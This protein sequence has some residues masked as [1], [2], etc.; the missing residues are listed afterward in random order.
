MAFNILIVD[1]SHVTRS[2][3][4]RTIKMAGVPVGELYNAENGQG[5]LDVLRAN[6]V[7]LVL[8]DITMPV[9]GAMEM[10]E[11]MSRDPEL[12]SVPVVIVSTEGSETKLEKMRQM[13]MRAFVKKPFMPDRIRE[14]M[15]EVLGG[16][17]EGGEDV[18]SDS[19]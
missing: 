17:E 10:L 14:V 8:A 1:D 9:M 7:D 12:R 5:A 3:I 13:G 16:W 4:A 2:M 18:S 15:R 6:W 19:F 11:K